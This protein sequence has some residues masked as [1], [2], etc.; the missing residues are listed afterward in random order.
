MVLSGRCRADCQT[1]RRTVSRASVTSL[2]RWNGLSRRRDNPF[3][4]DL[5][6][7]LTWRLLFLV[8]M[9]SVVWRS[10]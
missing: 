4:A 9:L 10:A 7:M 1:W 5:R 6:F 3:Y 2:T 8:G